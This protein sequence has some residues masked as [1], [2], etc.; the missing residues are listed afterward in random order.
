MMSAYIS[1]L[2]KVASYGVEEKNQYP[3]KAAFNFIE[4]GVPLESNVALYPEKQRNVIFAGDCSV[5]NVKTLNFKKKGPV[6]VLLY[7]EPD[8]AVN[9]PCIG[10]VRVPALNPEK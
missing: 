4:G 3:V 2:F 6:E 9:P 5:P 10:Y 7:Y 8:V 1:P